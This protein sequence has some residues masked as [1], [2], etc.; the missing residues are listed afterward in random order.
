LAGR[1]RRP[2][3]FGA[4]ADPLEFQSAGDERMRTVSRDVVAGSASHWQASTESGAVQMGSMFRVFA[5]VE[6][7]GTGKSG[8]IAEVTYP[9][10]WRPGSTVVRFIGATQKSSRVRSL[11]TGLRRHPARIYGN[12]GGSCSPGLRRPRRDVLATTRARLDRAAPHATRRRARSAIRHRRCATPAAGDERW[13]WWG[14][15][16]RPGGAPPGPLLPGIACRHACLEGVAALV[17]SVAHGPGQPSGSR[18]RECDEHRSGGDQGRRGRRGRRLRLAGLACARVGRATR[19][20][21]P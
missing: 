1:R 2:V 5:I 10:E 9:A 3:G 7:S 4:A 21:V 18:S 17:A 19:R 20:A 6:E 8:V 12:H 15:E 14:R 11:P 13:S 16:R